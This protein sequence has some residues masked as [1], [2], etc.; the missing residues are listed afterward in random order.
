MSYD[1]FSSMYLK[2]VKNWRMASPVKSR[3]VQIRFS[4]ILLI[5]NNENTLKNSFI[6]FY[7]CNLFYLNK[8]LSY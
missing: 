1:F 8:Y 5:L 6:M 7:A 3:L 2:Y 4:F